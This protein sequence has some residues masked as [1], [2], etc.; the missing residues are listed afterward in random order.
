MVDFAKLSAPFDPRTV[1]WRVGSTNK[2]AEE[3]RT[4]DP[5]AKA[6]KGQGLAYIDARIVMDRL[7]EVCGPD[8]WQ[9]KYSHAT[10]NTV[11][12]SAGRCGDEWSWKANGAGD[13]DIEAQK[14]ALS[15]AYK[16]AAGLWGIGR[17]LYDVESPWVP[18]D[19][20]GKITDA[21]YKTLDMALRRNT[22]AILS[23]ASQQPSGLD[24]ARNDIAAAQNA[25]T[26]PIT[27]IKPAGRL[28]AEKWVDDA[29]GTFKGP[30]FDVMAYRD[31]KTTP[32]TPK[33]TKTN[34][35]KL[36]ELR[37]KHPDLADRIDVAASALP[38]LAA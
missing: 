24:Q 22:Q 33:G 36:G 14:G 29:L 18:L 5:K 31:W 21:G 27:E 19:D 1:L 38:S 11:G 13:S 3:R 9:C 6:T 23:G 12:D 17:Y 7:D 32:C 4:N 26:Q 16:R 8:G 35:E 25:G 2:K 30:G 37:E 28:A 10:G 15:D 34:D 20:W